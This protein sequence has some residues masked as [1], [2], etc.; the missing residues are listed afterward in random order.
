MIIVKD[1]DLHGIESARD[2]C[3]LKNI[4]HA[5]R[6]IIDANINLRLYQINDK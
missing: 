3:H 1:S 6:D 2:R 4:V 5:R